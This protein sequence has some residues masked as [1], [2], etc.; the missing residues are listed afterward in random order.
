MRWMRQV[1]LF[2]IFAVDAEMTPSHELVQIAHQ[3][4]VEEVGRV[5]FVAVVI[6]PAC[7]KL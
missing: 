5:C 2:W 1:G 7:C 3:L 4:Q 6:V